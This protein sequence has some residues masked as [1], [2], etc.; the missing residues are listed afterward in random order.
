MEL[1]IWTP[2]EIVIKPMLLWCDSEGG[3]AH[4]NRSIN[5]ISPTGRS[6]TE[7]E[8]SSSHGGSQQGGVSKPTHTHYQEADRGQPTIGEVLD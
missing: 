2:Q 1:S 7:N 6:D 3:G 4:Y 8:R 5:G